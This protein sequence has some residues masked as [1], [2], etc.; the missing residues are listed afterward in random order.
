MTCGV[1]DLGFEY[2]ETVSCSVAVGGNDVD[3]AVVT[4]GGPSGVWRGA[5]VTLSK[6]CRPSYGV[7]GLCIG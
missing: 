3:M 5:L 7:F 2:P 6:R 1:D 4:V